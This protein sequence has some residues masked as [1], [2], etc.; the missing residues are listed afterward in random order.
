M[1]VIGPQGVSP[2][3]GLS[4][5][6]PEI[7]D[8]AHY[9]IG[10]DDVEVEVLEVG[11]WT[12]R[13][14]FAEEYH[15]DGTNV[16]ILGD[17]AHR[18]PP[19]FGLGSNTA[20]QDAYN[21]AWK[22]AYVRKGWAGPG[23]LKTYS[24]ERQPI[25]ETLVRESNNQIRAN[26]AVWQSLGL[27]AP[28]EDGVKYIAELSSVSPEGKAR[29]DKFHDALEAKR[30]E[31]ES[32]G[33]AYN[34]W[35]TSDA[36]YLGDETESR[37]EVVGDPI[38]NTQIS[39]YPGS[40]LPHVWLDLPARR[41]KISTH[42]IAGKGSFCLLVGVGGKPWELA[43]ERV[44]KATGIPLSTYGIGP[45]LNYIDIHRDWYR[46]R[47]VSDEGCVLVRP[48]R[49][50]AWR[51]SG[52]VEDHYDKLLVVLDAVLLRHEMSLET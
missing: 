5:N 16:F 34:H 9:L 48:D 13:E 32:L 35:Y 30:Q 6:S 8:L 44:K 43:A 23:L 3:K 28:P 19:T 12:I 52:R 2:F 1:A 17:A 27:A 40:R 25:G 11:H 38:V 20:I 42:D 10:D 22:V 37:P 21:L 33:L 4:V 51:S 50:V 18:H 36:V 47:G 31:L 45:G 39:T 41:K 24:P 46:K 15:K 49:F 26:T 7:A 14:T 29:R